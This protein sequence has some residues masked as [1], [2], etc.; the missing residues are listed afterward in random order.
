MN[1][2]KRLWALL[3]PKPIHEQVWMPARVTCSKCG[4]SFDPS[5]NYEW[6]CRRH[7][8]N[9]KP[10]PE[11]DIGFCSV[12]GI[13]RTDFGGVPITDCVCTAKRKHTPICRYLKAVGMMVSVGSCEPH[14]LDACEHC[15]CNCIG[16]PEPPC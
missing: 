12:C 9:P 1:L 6:V 3:T 5:N 7:A 13:V 8:P 11:Y 2:F 4:A 16:P 10:E 15:D 14:G